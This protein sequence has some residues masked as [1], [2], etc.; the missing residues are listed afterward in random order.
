MQSGKIELWVRVDENGEIPSS[1]MM[2]RLR[3]IFPNGKAEWSDGI[4]GMYGSF[5][6][7]VPCWHHSGITNKEEAIAAMQ[8][9]DRI[10]GYSSMKIGEL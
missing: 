9:Y 5:W 6:H 10:Y 3:I 8:Q 7:G 1:E 2:H 4:A